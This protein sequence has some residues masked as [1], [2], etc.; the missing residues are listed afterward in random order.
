M[1]E[2][3]AVQYLEV[4]FWTLQW[5]PENAVIIGDGALPLRSNVLKPYSSIGL[6]DVEK[7]LIIVYPVPDE[8]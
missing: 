5:M 4:V 1:V 6:C 3:V 2:Q 7:Y 8:L